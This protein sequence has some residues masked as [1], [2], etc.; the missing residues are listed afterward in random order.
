[1]V[2]EKRI[3]QKVV[4]LLT[5]EPR[6][7]KKGNAEYVRTDQQIQRLKRTNP[8]RWRTLLFNLVQ[9][10]QA[11]DRER[12]LQAQEEIDE[13]NRSFRPRPPLATC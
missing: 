11:I 9:A 6:T 12:T 1:M 5:D 7:T 3:E 10:V 13:F 4:A 8:V 2:N